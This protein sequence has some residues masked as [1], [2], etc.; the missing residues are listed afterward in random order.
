MQN[1]FENTISRN[2]TLENDFKLL[3]AFAK[4][5]VC[6]EKPEQKLV[7]KRKRKNINA[8]LT[9]FVSV[10]ILTILIVTPSV[11][12]PQVHESVLMTQPQYCLLGGTL[13]YIFLKFDI[14]AYAKVCG[15][16]LLF[17]FHLNTTY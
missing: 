6:S 10:R 12:K 3:T 5:D 8:P 2:M 11:I 15:N 7:T 16:N 17:V 14:S 13:L 4:L 9:G 1:V